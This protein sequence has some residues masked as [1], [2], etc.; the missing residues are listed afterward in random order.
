MKNTQKNINKNKFTGCLLGLACG[1]YL[2]LP[3]EYLAT[4]KT[5]AYF[6]RYSHPDPLKKIHT[7]RGSLPSGYYSDDTAQMICLAESL[8]DQNFNTTN[9]LHLYRKW[10][11]E[12]HATPQADDKAIGVG[13]H[14]FKVLINRSRVIPTTI[15]NNDK[16]GGNGALMRC[17]PIGLMYFD[18]RDLLLKRSILSALVTHNNEIAAFSC[19]V[20]NFFISYSIIGLPKQLFCKKLRDDLDYLPND[21]VGILNKDFHKINPENLKTTGY[22]LFTL[23]IALY[24]FFVTNTFQDCI[25]TSIKIGG[26]TDTQAAVA[27]ALAG[28]F[29]GEDAIPTK[30]VTSLMRHQYISGLA[31]SIY[32]KKCNNI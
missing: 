9:Q 18:N 4:E 14:T 22:S 32:L 26:D 31:K 3:F 24:S 1:D 6:N 12:G 20:L 23:E 2:G 19:V 27:G 8:I 10:L 28:A 17:A 11:L 13:Q 29:Y 7:K 15:T 21:I 30:W 25:T 5:K 16:E